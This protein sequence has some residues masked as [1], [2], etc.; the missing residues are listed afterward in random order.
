M[1]YYKSWAQG[2]IYYEQLRVVVDMNDSR[3]WAHNSK[4]FEQLKVVNDINYFGSWAEG[5]GCYE[6]LSIM[7]DMNNSRSCEVKPIDAK[8]SSELWI[9]WIYLLHEVKVV[10]DMNEFGSWV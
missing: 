9:I 10:D 4:C 2:S 3:S 6:Q 1:K 8:Y 5:Y 7:D